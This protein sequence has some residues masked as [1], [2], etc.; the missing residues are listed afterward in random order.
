MISEKDKNGFYFHDDRP[1]YYLSFDALV[2][3]M[4]D[5]DHH[6][7]CCNL[8]AYT[9]YNNYIIMPPPRPLQVSGLTFASRILPAKPT[10]HAPL[11]PPDG[12]RRIQASARAVSG[13]L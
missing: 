10:Y 2:Y 9:G 7:C 12:L 3:S 13:C 5:F 1:T 11:S 4:D 6:G 8:Q